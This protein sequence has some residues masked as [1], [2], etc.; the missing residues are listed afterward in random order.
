MSDFEVDYFFQ[1]VKHLFKWALSKASPYAD[2]RP[3]GTQKLCEVRD[4][5]FRTLM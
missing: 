1:R 5:D 4:I 2:G 3:H